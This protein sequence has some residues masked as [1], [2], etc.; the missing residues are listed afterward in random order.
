MATISNH[1]I[2]TSRNDNQS[3][4]EQSITSRVNYNFQEPFFTLVVVVVL[5]F[6]ILIHLD[7]YGYYGNYG[8]L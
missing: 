8:Y 5:G 2:K 7:G 1:V 6:V 4:S 3:H